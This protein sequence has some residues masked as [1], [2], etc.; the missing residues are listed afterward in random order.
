VT[1]RAVIIDLIGDVTNQGEGAIK[2]AYAQALEKD[3]QRIFFN[4]SDTEYINT[5]GIA[6]LISLVMEAQRSE[7]RI[8]LYGMSSHYRKVFELVRFPLYADVYQTEEDALA[9]V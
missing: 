7:Y 8:G 1:D 2:T 3:P 9:T 5:S 4:F 6:V